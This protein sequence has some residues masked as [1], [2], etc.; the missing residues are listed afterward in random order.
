MFFVFECFRCLHYGIEG[1]FSERHLI[2]DGHCTCVRRWPAA[3]TLRQPRGHLES[4]NGLLP[5]RTAGT[6]DQGLP[7]CW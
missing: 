6:H 7:Y 2:E 5:C 3:V 4:L 1:V